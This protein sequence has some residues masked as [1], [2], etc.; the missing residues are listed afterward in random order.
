MSKGG[1]H[2]ANGKGWAEGRVQHMGFVKWAMKKHS[3]F[4][5]YIGYRV[6]YYPAMGRYYYDDPY[7]TTSIRRF[8]FLAQM[9]DVGCWSIR[10]MLWALQAFRWWIFTNQHRPGW[11]FGL[12]HSSCRYDVFLMSGSVNM[13]IIG[14]TLGGHQK[15]KDCQ[16]W[17]GVY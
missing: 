14:N 8:F 4:R 2:S 3:L 10:F 17:Q 12:D 16:G 7:E 5:V 1:H 6:L 9:P 11:L 15:V 13:E